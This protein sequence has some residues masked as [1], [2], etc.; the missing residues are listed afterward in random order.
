MGALEAR[1]ANVLHSPKQDSSKHD[2]ADARAA[3]LQRH[4][5]AND[6]LCGENGRLRAEIARLQTSCG[7]AAATV[8]VELKNDTS[9]VVSEDIVNMIVSAL[10]HVFDD[11]E[12]PEESTPQ[13]CLAPENVEGDLFLGHRASD[14]LQ[15]AETA[16][17]AADICQDCTECIAEPWKL[18]VVNAI[19]TAASSVLQDELTK[20][21]EIP[22]ADEVAALVSE[23]IALRELVERQQDSIQ[24]L[25]AELNSAGA[26]IPIAGS[27]GDA[28]SGTV[29]RGISGASGVLSASLSAV[30]AP[31]V[32][33]ADKKAAIVG[34][35]YEVISRGGVV[36]RSGESL[37]SE[38]TG[39]LAP[40]SRVRVVALSAA[41]PR[42]IEVVCIGNSCRV[43]SE[44]LGA[45]PGHVVTE[46]QSNLEPETDSPSKAAIQA[47]IIGWISATSRDAVPLIRL[48]PT[49][50]DNL[51][52][53]VDGEGNEEGD[54][55]VTHVTL[56][57]VEWEG[58]H[59]D[60]E[61]SRQ[62]IEMLG[63]QLNDTGHRLLQSFEMKS[64]LGE[65]QQVVLRARERLARMRET[66][67]MAT[68]DVHSFHSESIWKATLEEIPLTIATMNNTEDKEVPAA[69]PAC[70]MTGAKP[71]S[72]YVE[73]CGPL[74]SVAWDRIASE[75]E[76]TASALY[77]ALQRISSLE[78][79][80]EEMQKE[81]EAAECVGRGELSSLRETLRHLVEPTLTSM[82]RSGVPV[83]QLASAALSS[84]SFGIS[85]RGNSDTT[86]DS[87]FRCRLQDLERALV[88]LRCELQRCISNEAALQRSVKARRAALCSLLHRAATDGLVTTNCGPIMLPT[89]A[90]AERQALQ[91]A[92]EEQLRWNLQLC[93]RSSCNM[94]PLPVNRM[95]SVCSSSVY[96]DARSR[97]SA[98][99]EHDQLWRDQTTAV[100]CK[101]EKERLDTSVLLRTDNHNAN[102]ISICLIEQP[103]AHDRCYEIQ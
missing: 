31:K 85:N 21:S 64:V 2:T 48:A 75:R 40:G 22:S 8:A 28:L 27:L 77:A 68:E 69:A 67:D 25:E 19:T 87:L 80:A 76:T 4:N 20:P 7:P 56:S 32:D 5:A 79:E 100:C 63:A 103:I 82:T 70:K 94:A 50:A 42:R 37:A 91:A 36:V 89:S 86:D 15:H 12:E 84:G 18:Q 14:E 44:E 51:E 98:T 74:D 66:A 99:A 10:H 101:D 3:M 33:K 92:V 59:Q 53:S 35:E 81:Q 88:D 30:L 52:A 26:A 29:V 23:K 13:T 102:F 34:A 97:T 62:K 90:N 6:Q 41:Y 45:N 71:S 54:N 61:A 38:I 17:G 47:P 49:V 78:R 11:I 60:E 57:S 95:T 96:S 43:S 72:A 83:L 24:A 58:L 1:A 65:L 39:E 55:E 9:D 73:E 16:S 93:H 46:P